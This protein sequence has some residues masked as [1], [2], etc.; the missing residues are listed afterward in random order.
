M[1]IYGERKGIYMK[2]KYRMAMVMA[3]L[4][5][6][7]ILLSSCKGQSL[8]G[9]TAGEVA[10][11]VTN[12]IQEGNGGQTGIISEDMQQLLEEI[13]WNAM[14]DTSWQDNT[15]DAWMATTNQLLSFKGMEGVELY[16]KN[17]DDFC[18]TPEGAS[19]FMSRA[20]RDQ[21]GN[22]IYLMERLRCTR[23]GRVE[24]QIFAKGQN[25]SKP[26]VLS[27]GIMAGTNELWGDIMVDAEGSNVTTGS[28]KNESEKE[29]NLQILSQLTDDSTIKD[30]GKMVAIRFLGQD[31]D[32]ESIEQFMIDQEGRI[33]LHTMKMNYQQREDDT[34]IL[35]T[36][37][38]NYLYIASP[39]GELLFMK[40]LT[41]EAEDTAQL[42]FVVL[43]NGEVGIS[44]FDGTGSNRKLTLFHYD[45]ATAELKSLAKLNNSYLTNYA[46]AISDTGKVISVDSG[47]IWEGDA[48]DGERKQLYTWKEHGIR[49]RSVYALSA[50]IH[51]VIDVVY[52]DAEGAH[53][54]SIKPVTEHKEITE[55]IMAVS[56]VTEERCREAVMKFNQKYP[57][58]HLTLKVGYDST[59]LSS[60]LISGDGPVLVDTNLTGFAALQ[61]YW[62]PL[63]GVLETMGLLDELEPK[64]LEAGKID[65]VTYGIITDFYLE[66]LITLDPDTKNWNY[67][68]FLDYL[69]AHP[70][71][72]YIYD[73]YDPNC[74]SLFV[75]RFWQ[76]GLDDGILLNGSKK[77]NYIDT[78]RF[79]TVLR[80]ANSKCQN[81]G[82]L[83]DKD[84]RTRLYDGETSFLLTW[85]FK[86]SDMALFRLI[87]G[88][89]AYI[90]GEPMQD[91]AA[92]FLRSSDPITIRSTASLEEK[93]GALLFIKELLSYDS[94]M[95]ASKENNF[96]LSV[97]KDVLKEC[98]M[99]MTSD[100]YLDSNIYL[101]TRNAVRLGDKVDNQKDYQQLQE[102]LEN[103]VPVS[104]LPKELSTILWD[105]LD[106]YFNGIVSQAD[107]IRKLKNRVNL[108]LQEQ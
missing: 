97:R 44:F 2:L 82:K 17:A 68:A 89:D 100:T 108:Y 12:G 23:D 36:S 48:R 25:P 26:R 30:G 75:Y 34:K 40:T 96:K 74:A 93:K 47:G 46:L 57:S 83:D 94:Q 27:Y 15:L 71:R 7:M 43:P 56:S 104:N 37:P 69:L 9:T 51:D 33:Y 4:L 107:M 18:M 55:L 87:Y 78:E 5:T 63:D 95:S 73:D 29:A 103:A 42:A 6:L 41:R 10:G 105:E 61:K 50:T 20:S 99:S 38:E 79:R 86:P 21:N 102:L 14:D 19:I 106:P 81:E 39:Q 88:D 65:G 1:G 64:A 28:D 91:G 66:T 80:L 31:C 32:S 24:D 58:Y 72:P 45:E 85:F 11:E 60:E 92:H 16:G 90:V 98:I 52:T 101:G 67:D 62:E 70:E 76:H 54:L 59:R 77:E 84:S 3:V 13:D 35:L 49:P 8:G 22:I 53:Y